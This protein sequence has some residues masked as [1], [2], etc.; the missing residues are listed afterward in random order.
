MPLV[1]VNRAAS[2]SAARGWDEPDAGCG[3]HRGSA[4]DSSARGR[5]VA[6]GTG[7]PPECDDFF[8][9]CSS[10]RNTSTT[11]LVCDEAQGFWRAFDGAESIETTLSGTPDSA[12]AASVPYAAL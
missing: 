12:S 3:L 6:H 2:R 4:P 7:F 1:R 8:L 10:H 11:V 9:R 5:F